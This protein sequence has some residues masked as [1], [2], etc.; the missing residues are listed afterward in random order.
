MNGGREL[1]G[2]DKAALD[3]R[4]I[5]HMSLALDMRIVLRTFALLVTGERVNRDALVAAR[6]SEG[7]VSVVID[8]PAFMSRTEL[9][10]Q[11]RLVDS[12]QTAALPSPR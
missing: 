4:Y 1:S 6:E 10:M 9:L 3:M 12:Q 11:A 2:E 8:A 7:C 5:H